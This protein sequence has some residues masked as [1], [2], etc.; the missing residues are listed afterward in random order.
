MNI[1]DLT[2][3]EAKKLARLFGGETAV[4]PATP[5]VPRSV[6]VRSRDAGV[7]V[8]TLIGYEGRTVTLK[9]ARQMWQWKAAQGGTLFDCATYGVDPNKSK[10]S[11]SNARVIILDACA[12]IDCTDAAI[13]TME[14]VKW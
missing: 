5:F 10:F 1:D 2:I 9:G 6:I 14:T 7:Q 3:G 12:I 4:S 13:K 11:A 8:G